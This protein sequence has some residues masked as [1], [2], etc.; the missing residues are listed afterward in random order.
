MYFGVG[1][2]NGIAKAKVK[3]CK[4]LPCVY[5]KKYITNVKQEQEYI[6]SAYIGVKEK[7]T[8]L[9]ELA[10]KQV[11]TAVAMIVQ[12]HH[13]MLE[14]KGCFEKILNLIEEQKVQAEWAL[15]YV[16]GEYI[17]LFD[18]YGNSYQRAR[19][20][21]LMEILNLLE[22]EV[23]KKK[24]CKMRTSIAKDTSEPFIAFGRQF[25]VEDVLHLYEQG[26]IGIVDLLGE[27]ESHIFVV[28]KSLE[29]PMIIKLTK[30]SLCLVGKRC[31]M[32]G[33]QGSVK[34]E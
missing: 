32:D 25:S 18:Q 3:F 12:G 5:E 4:D 16:F 2:S 1:V 22:Q 26:A 23:Q 33:S 13:Q 34:A 10:I 30:E 21:D 11:G 17:K 14:D 29:I 8:I 27:V 28:A 7:L 15:Q 20:I 24:E 31:I 9:Y 19:R 6:R